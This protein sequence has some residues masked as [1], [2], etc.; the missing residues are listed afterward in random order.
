ME[1]EIISANL[2]RIGITMG[3]FNGIGPE[4]ILKTLQD[5]RINRLCVPIIYGSSKILA[6]YKKLLN[7]EQFQYHQVVDDYRFNDRRVNVVNCWEDNY[8][9][10]PGKS[11]PEAGRS[12]F[13]ALA[14]SSADL[15]AGLIH[16]V[17]TA[18]INKFNIQSD[19]FPYPGH[20]EYY[21][22]QF[23]KA[24]S[25][26]LLVAENLRIGTVTGHLPLIQV[27]AALTR[28]LISNKLDMLLQSLREDFGLKKPRIAVLGLN[29]HAGE[30]GLLGDEE[31]AII[32]PVVNQYKEKG[33][34]V[35]GP[36]P[37]DGF[38]G[39]HT[40]QK[41]DAVLAMYHDQGLIPFKMLGFETGVNFT[42]GL[43]VVRTSPDHGTAYDIA[44]T[45]VAD[46][47][48]FCSALFLALDVLKN[49]ALYAEQRPK[50]EG[51][52]IVEL[53]PVAGEHE[54]RKLQ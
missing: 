49:R 52:P 40:Y 19:D 21:A 10:S 48:S 42:A 39:M 5:N 24:G 8:E 33:H 12:A 29:P 22:A 54:L 20:T 25:L 26:M 35:F 31:L 41:F 46:E 13:L 7:I 47:S 44:G 43:S 23:G 30:D 4:V 9:I 1:N 28:E 2:P 45:G 11:L 50:R 3:D 16:A 37:A 38:F 17:V 27:P 36:F 15:K 34:L 18:P 51:K 14:K 32:A 53:K 6:K